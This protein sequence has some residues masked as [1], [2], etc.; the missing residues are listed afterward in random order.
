MAAAA[1]T[2]N[3]V[4]AIKK[5]NTDLE[6]LQEKLTE[7]KS[8]LQTDLTTEHGIGLLQVK[9]HAMMQYSQLSLFYALLK[10]EQPD[11]ANGHPVFKELVR[12]RTI[13]ERIRPL[14]RKLKYQVDK[15]C[16]MAVSDAKDLD[17]ALSYAPNPDA[18]VGD[19]EGD[20]DDTNDQSDR[21]EAGVYKAPRLASVPYEEEEKAAEKQAKRDERNRKRM[22]KSTILSE[23][24][25]EYSERPEELQTS[26]RTIDKETLREEREK[27]DYE[28]SRFVRVVTSRKDKIRKRQRERDAIAADSIGKIDNFAGIHDA[29]GDSGGKRF[30]PTVTT[31]KKVGG[32]VGGIF[33]HLDDS[34][35]KKKG[36][37]TTQATNSRRTTDSGQQSSSSRSDGP[38]TA[39]AAKKQK[40]RF[41]W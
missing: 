3:T 25:D 18:M 32:K 17:A 33:S 12:Y 30:T 34:T 11:K 23:I 28:E 15:L 40:V 39:S 24:R 1:S 2:S 5:L 8:A 36:G 7:F 20:D 13:L 38:A 26:G 9:N 14:D 22:A 29:L 35:G 41:G 10:I 19:D 4:D 6:S 31:Q 37:K 27:V 16:K 21:K